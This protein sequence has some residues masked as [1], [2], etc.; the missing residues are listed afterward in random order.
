MKIPKTLEGWIVIAFGV[1]ALFGVAISVTNDGD[2]TTVSV[3]VDT[4]HGPTDITAKTGDVEASGAG[5]H[6]HMKNAP[7]QAIE[8]SANAVAD[9]A[10]ETNPLSP[11]APLAAPFQPGCR[12]QFI[13]GNFSSRF[14]TGPAWLTTHYTVSGNLP[15]FRDLNALT[16]YASDRRNGVSWHYNLDREGNCVYTVRETN[17]AWTQAAANRLSI[18]I[19]VINRGRGDAPLFTKSG[20]RKYARILSDIAYRWNIPIQRGQANKSTCAVI[21]K[22]LIDHNDLGTCGGIIT[23]SRPTT[24][25][26]S[27]RL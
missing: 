8:T 25:T 6:D 26:T 13:Q 14:G 5:V 9:A 2:A 20:L 22:G 12:S 21:R 11:F 17:A 15:G 27:S 1:L 19:E 10:A 24:S 18:G 4:P 7:S 3:T 16:A 23:T